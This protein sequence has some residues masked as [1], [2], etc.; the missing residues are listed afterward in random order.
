MRH[1][2]VRSLQDLE[3]PVVA[4]VLQAAVELNG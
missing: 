4:A 2:K 1:I 3:N